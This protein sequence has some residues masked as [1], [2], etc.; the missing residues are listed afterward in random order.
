MA[1]LGNSGPPGFPELSGQVL[2]RFPNRGQVLLQPMLPTL[3]VTDRASRDGPKRVLRGDEEL[4]GRKRGDKDDAS[5]RLESQDVRRGRVF[6][7]CGP[8]ARKR[9]IQESG[10]FGLWRRGESRDENVKYAVPPVD[11]AVSPTGGPL[12]VE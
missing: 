9:G 2:G 11:L 4:C 10:Q 12:S 5:V 7:Q 8:L 6:L 3:S 1:C